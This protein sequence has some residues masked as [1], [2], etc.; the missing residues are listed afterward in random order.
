MVAPDQVAQLGASTVIWSSWVLVAS[1]LVLL[2]L[3]LSL[4]FVLEGRLRRLRDERDALSTR[5]SC[6][7]R[8]RDA[9]RAALERETE[10]ARSK[11]KLLSTISHDIRTPLASVVGLAEL[12]LREYSKTE[13]QKY[14]RL[15][16]DES[17]RLASMIDDH[18]IPKRDRSESPEVQSDSPPRPKI[19]AIERHLTRST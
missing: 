15:L 10:I 2:G 8:E 12:L 13:R 16:I 6:A 9:L 14:L 17:Y 4:A 3:S 7:E 5:L 11:T 1:A 19:V 18:L